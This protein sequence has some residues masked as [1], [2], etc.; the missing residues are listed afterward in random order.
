MKHISEILPAVADRI[1]QAYIARVDREKKE[2][3]KTTN[4]TGG[5][6]G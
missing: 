3:E 4:T 6:N 2:A 1:I 5:H